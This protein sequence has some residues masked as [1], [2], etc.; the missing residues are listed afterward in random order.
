MGLRLTPENEKGGGAGVPARQSAQAGK[1]VP[2]EELFET[3]PAKST[4]MTIGSLQ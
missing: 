1:P 2:P 3:A 4:L